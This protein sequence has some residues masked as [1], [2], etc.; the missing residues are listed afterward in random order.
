[1]KLLVHNLDDKD[2][3]AKFSNI[4]KD[5]TVIS[6]SNEIHHCIGCFG[7]W[8]KTPAA[9]VIRDKYGDMGELLSKC[10]EL[11]I[12]SKCCYGGFEPF[13]KNVMDRSI[14][15]IH[16]YF[17]TRNKEMHHRKRYKNCFSL[18]VCFYGTDIDKEEMETAK[19]LVVANS[20]NFNCTKQEVIFFSSIEEMDGKI[21]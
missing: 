8:V 2:F 1:M 17:T 11:V 15:Y 19:K 7:C 5:T 6:S 3:K 13:V 4:N 14:S 21:I 12:I 9:C 18:K 20:I 10:E 16:P